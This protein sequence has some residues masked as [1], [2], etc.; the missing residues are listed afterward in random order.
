M[1]IFAENL[2]DNYG[3]QRIVDALKKYAPK[4]VEFTNHEK[5]ADVVVI[6]AF[7]QRRKIEKRIKWIRERGQ[8]YAMVQIALRSTANPD[9]RDWIPLWDMAR[10][11]WSYYPLM[12]WSDDDGYEPVFNFCYA[13][14]GVDP[15]V[16]QELKVPKKYHMVIGE[17]RD[18]SVRECVKAAQGLVFQLGAGISDVELASVYSQSEFVSGLRRKEG[19][20]MPVLEGLLCGARPICY[21]KPHYRYWFGDLAEYIPEASPEEV[22]KSL[23]ALIDEGPR[24]VTDQEKQLVRTKFAWE[25]IVEK[26]WKKALILR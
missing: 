10:V 23:T 2:I 1:K 13:P 6:Y 8:R 25:P 14:L 17:N 19:F 11:V 3:I 18:E 20:E 15:E 22:I 26:F 16:F 7:G 4:D 5:S 21:D 12:H 24:P 9:T